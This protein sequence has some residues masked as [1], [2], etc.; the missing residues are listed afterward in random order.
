[1]GFFRHVGRESS[2]RSSTEVPQRGALD[3]EHNA[4]HDTCCGARSLLEGNAEDQFVACRILWCGGIAHA[5]ASQTSCHL[6]CIRILVGRWTE[7]GTSEVR[8]HPD[9]DLIRGLV[10]CI[11]SEEQSSAWRPYVSA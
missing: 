9:P 5:S 2:L 6:A 3:A 1:M 4:E 10:Y 7:A 11:V 8:S